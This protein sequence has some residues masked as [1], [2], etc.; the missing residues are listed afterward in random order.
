M[1]YYEWNIED[2][3]HGVFLVSEDTDDFSFMNHGDVYYSGSHYRIYEAD[4][5]TNQDKLV[6]SILDRW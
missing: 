2:D 5:E 1:I 6:P 3:Y 4:H